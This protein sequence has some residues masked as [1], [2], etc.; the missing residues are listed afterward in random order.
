MSNYYSNLPK[1]ITYSILYDVALLG[2]CY[3]HSQNFPIIHRDL[4]SN[5]I[6]LTPNMTAKISDLGVAKI[7]NLTLYRWVAWHRLP[8]H[9]TPACNMP[10]EVMVA[11][12][13]YDTSIDKFSYGIILMIHIAI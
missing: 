1:E 5:D 13:R 8:Q 7:L 2:L 9:G 6:L 10:P 11:D 12:P 4:S 3:L